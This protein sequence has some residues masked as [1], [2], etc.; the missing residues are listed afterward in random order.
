MSELARDWWQSAPWREPDPVPA[1][2]YDV[3]DP[4]AGELNPTCKHERTSYDIMTCE[5]CR[6]FTE[7]LRRAKSAEEA[8]IIGR[9]VS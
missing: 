5:A 3:R 7:T 8:S 6:A 2:P 9:P 1:K 4:L